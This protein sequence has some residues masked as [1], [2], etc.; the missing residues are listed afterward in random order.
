VIIFFDELYNMSQ[1]IEQENKRKM[2]EWVMLLE[3]VALFLPAARE[4]AEQLQGSF[5]LKE[6]LEK[7]LSL[8]STESFSYG[9]LLF[10]FH[11]LLNRKKSFRREG[12]LNA[13]CFSSLQGGRF[14]PKKVIGIIGMNEEVFPPKEPFLDFN[15][16]Q[17][18]Q[19]K[20]PLQE[21]LYKEI[22]LES[23]HLAKDLFYLSASVIS[24]QFVEY[25]KAQGIKYSLHEEKLI[26]HDEAYFLEE[27]PFKNSSREAFQRASFLQTKEYPKKFSLIASNSLSPSLKKDLTIDCHELFSF[28]RHPLKSYLQKTVGLKELGSYEKVAQESFVFN[29]LD[30]S[31]ALQSALKGDNYQELFEEEGNAPL[32]PFKHLAFQQMDREIEQ[33]QAALLDIGVPISYIVTLCFAQ[34]CTMPYQEDLILY[35]PPLMMDLEQK[36]TFIVIFCSRSIIKGGK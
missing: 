8:E 3:K 15:L 19:K 4:D 9:T 36:I 25:L 22:F 30:K 10:F 32:G 33:I 6:L 31:K 28:A 23:L 24:M 21:D 26:S 16:L 5:A 12:S 20:Y 14:I 2:C 13:I 18:T 34:E 35:L 7:L 11:A 29:A 27:S 17:I 1:S